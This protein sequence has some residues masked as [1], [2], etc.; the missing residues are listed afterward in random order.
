MTV[1]DPDVVAEV[2]AQVQAYEDALMANDLE[3]L[4]GFFWR[5]P[6]TTRFGVSEN[7]HGFD[8]IAAFRV[9]RVG[10]SPT[11]TQT[12]VDVVALGRDV[13]VANVEFLRASGQAGRQSQTWLRTAEGWRVCSAHVSL[14][15]TKVDQRA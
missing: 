1:N 3:A 13:A 12:R 14:L 7:L 11:R 5:S 8:E 9:G 6:L 15:Q 2:V 10:G 4:D